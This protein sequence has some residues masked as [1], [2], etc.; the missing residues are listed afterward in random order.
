MRCAQF[1]AEINQ[2]S[3]VTVQAGDVFGGLDG[4]Q[5]D[6]IVSNPPFH[7]EF[8]VNTNV[9]HRIMREAKSRLSTGGRLVIVANAFLNYEDV[10]TAHLS[11]ARVV[12]RNNR[13]VVIEGRR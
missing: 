6:L 1:S 13:F 4:Q 7:K 5:F 10:M 9:A 3:D 11:R 12:A 2:L 8:D